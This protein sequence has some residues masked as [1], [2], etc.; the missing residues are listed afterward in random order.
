MFN[1]A[2]SVSAVAIFV[3]IYSPIQPSQ[4][5]DQTSGWTLL[6][7]EDVAITDG[8]VRSMLRPTS[9]RPDDQINQDSCPRHGILFQA[10]PLMII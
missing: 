7:F 5:I 10:D 8:K 4:T 9:H 2:D 3:F 1:A 6:V